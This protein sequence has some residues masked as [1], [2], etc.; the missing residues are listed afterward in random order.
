LTQGL[1]ELLEPYLGLQGMQAGQHLQQHPLHISGTKAK[2]INVA[3]KSKLIGSLVAKYDADVSFAA[4]PA[5]W[6]TVIASV[7]FQ[8]DSLQKRRPTFWRYVTQQNS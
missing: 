5:R 8:Y 1:V 2:A 4:I 3:V 6:Q 7:E